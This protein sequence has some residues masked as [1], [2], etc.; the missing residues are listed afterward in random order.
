MIKLVNAGSQL[1]QIFCG[2]E[3]EEAW[4]PLTSRMTL[5]TAEEVRAGKAQGRHRTISVTSTPPLLPKA[6]MQ[7]WS[8]LKILCSCHDDAL[9]HLKMHESQG[10]KLWSYMGIACFEAFSDEQALNNGHDMSCQPTE[11]QRDNTSQH[12]S[13]ADNHH[14]QMVGEK[15]LR[16]PGKGR[17]TETRAE[18]LS[19]NNTQRS[20]SGQMHKRPENSIP[21]SQ[22]ASREKFAKLISI[23]KMKNLEK[24][25]IMN[26]NLH[27][28]N[29]KPNKLHPSE[30]TAKS[31]VNPDSFKIDQ[32]QASHSNGSSA[33]DTKSEN[34]KKEKKKRKV[35]ER[36]MPPTSKPG[37]VTGKRKIAIRS[38]PQAAACKSDQSENLNKSSGPMQQGRVNELSGVVES[39]R[40]GNLDQKEILSPDDHEQLQRKLCWRIHQFMNS[41]QVNREQLTLRMVMD[42]VSIHFGSNWSKI[43]KEHKKL[44]R[45]EVM[46]IFE[47]SQTHRTDSANETIEIV[48]SDDEQDSS[49]PSAEIT[50]RREGKAGAEIEPIIL[51]DENEESE[52][53]LGGSSY[54]L[55]ID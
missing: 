44:I 11:L 28:K 1:V 40:C 14:S 47:V 9:N 12:T 15:S 4:E 8:R 55:T 19:D 29:L 36:K 42:G 39:Q 49:L 46:R 45:S 53:P 2:K 17:E 32:L 7:E 23:A 6:L 41:F 10:R 33:P 22:Q 18:P 25:K 20:L 3:D 38:C 43:V 34:E 31:D 48:S 37:A 5:R 35:S 52:D 54:F 30:S 24:L 21:S 51:I 50:S 27:A 13:V 26:S 16:Q